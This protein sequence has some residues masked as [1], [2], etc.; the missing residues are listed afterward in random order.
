VSVLAVG[1]SHRTAPVALLERVALSPG[2][3]TKLVQDLLDA[4]HVTEAVVL[5]T[6]NRVEVYADITKFHGGVADV[7]EL[8]ARHTGV[9][10]DTI[11]PHLFVHYEDRAV[12][13]L[14]SVAC[15]LDSMVVGESQILG[16]VRQALRSAQDAGSAG[17]TL[18]ELLQQALRVGKRAHAE[19]DVDRAGHSLV[20]VGLELATEQLGDLS[21]RSALVV[22]AGSMSSLA[23]TTLRR[24][25][26]GRIVIANRTMAHA[27]R[28]AASVDGAAVPFGDLEQALASAD[29]VI[30]CTG[31][32]G[33]V[34][35]AETVAAARAERTAPQFFL[36]LALPRDIDPGVR[37]L[38]GVH[39]V[40][41]DTLAR[42]LDGDERAADVDGVRR[43]VTEEVASFVGWQRATSVAPTVV[44][45]R[46]MAEDVVSSELTRLAGRLPD[47]DDRAREEIG[48]TV[49][50]V[51]DKLLHSP[52]VRVKE[53]AEE[54]GGHAYAEALQQLFGL[55]L[56]K[57]DVISRP[58][59]D[60]PE[61]GVAP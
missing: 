27:E 43:I 5:S 47:I 33:T 42:V 7:S 58:A 51:V 40:D 31:A 41:L 24:S 18:H 9:D 56:R 29:L 38:D 30:S 35:S 52:T 53:L 57:I 6:C 25:G 59:A 48:Q 22:G 14:F 15:G 1:L 4:E 8:L 46:S 10:L 36:D 49:R 44:A 45:L 54:P 60:L 37:A 17:R 21:G 3:T 13:H 26:A 39:V 61:P 23:A 34:V 32:V 55:D 16:Q 28:L 20:T 50:R 12:Q 2:A 11:T 19:T